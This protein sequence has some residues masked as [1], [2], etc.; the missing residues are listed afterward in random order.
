MSHEEKA[1]TYFNEEFHCSQAVFAAFADELGI[2][3]EQA[4]K[5][6]HCFNGGMRKGAICGTCAGAL[7][8]LGMKYGQTDKDDSESEVKADEKAVEF[9]ER[10]KKKNGSY[11]CDEL[12]GCDI[13]TVAGIQY[14]EEHNC[15]TKVCPRMIASAVR[16]LEDM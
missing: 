3:E 13:S 16:F 1:L 5:I 7:M 8:V 12:L 2:T 9:L 15:F 4:L 14:A 11:I 10:F 6:A